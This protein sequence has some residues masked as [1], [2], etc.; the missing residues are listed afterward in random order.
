MLKWNSATKKVWNVLKWRIKFWWWI[1]MWKLNLDTRNSE[2]IS[3]LGTTWPKFKNPYSRRPKLQ[4]RS[5]HHRHWHLLQ[6]RRRSNM[7]HR[8][9]RRRSNPYRQRQF[10]NKCLPKVRLRS[11]PDGLQYAN[12][13]WVWVYLENKINAIWF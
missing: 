10:R 12:D 11:H 9:E 7:R 4:H 3:T 1:D 2:D 5:T 8:S 6:N 13:G